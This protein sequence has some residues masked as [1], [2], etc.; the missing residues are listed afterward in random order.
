[1]GPFFHC[2]VVGLFTKSC[3]VVSCVLSL[4][5]VS[6]TLPVAVYYP[7]YGLVL[8][9]VSAIFFSYFLA[10]FQLLFRSGWF[11]WHYRRWWWRCQIP[12]YHPDLWRRFVFCGFHLSNRNIGRG[13]YCGGP[14]WSG[15]RIE[16]RPRCPRHANACR[17]IVLVFRSR[18]HGT[19]HVWVV[20]ITPVFVILSDLRMLKVVVHFFVVAMFGLFGLRHQF[21]AVGI[22]LFSIP[23][24]P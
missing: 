6:T 11:L 9:S 12:I 20:E 22:F 24:S 10:I 8:D 15:C 2:L 1:M 3:S 18:I 4:S 19:N 16:T 7:D 17:I 23:G 21:I 13:W 5:F 14:S